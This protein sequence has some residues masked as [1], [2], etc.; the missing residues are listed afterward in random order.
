LKSISQSK[1]CNAWIFAKTK[2]KPCHVSFIESHFIKD[3]VVKR[4]SFGKCLCQSGCKWK[5][6]VSIHKLLA[7]RFEQWTCCQFDFTFAACKFDVVEVAVLLQ[8]SANCCRAFPQNDICSKGFLSCTVHPFVGWCMFLLL[9]C[10]FFG[11]GNCRGC[12]LQVVGPACWCRLLALVLLVVVAV[13][14]QDCSALA[15]R[16]WWSAGDGVSKCLSFAFEAR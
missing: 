5:T 7:R 12:Q 11:G 13:A 6:L 9:C 2:S 1:S 16:G 8:E 3:K 4:S 14:T 15:M 10:V